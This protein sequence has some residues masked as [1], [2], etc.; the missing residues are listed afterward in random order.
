MPRPNHPRSVAAATVAAYPCRLPSLRHRRPGAAYL[1][2]L[3]LRPAAPG[4][5]SV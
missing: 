5:R 4:L 3:P 2:R 1:C